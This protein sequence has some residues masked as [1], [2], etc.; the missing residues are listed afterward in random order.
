MKTKS[1]VSMTQKYIDNDNSNPQDV[2]VKE[3]VF[4][5]FGLVL[6]LIVVLVGVV[7]IGV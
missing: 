6:H 1:P 3:K 4:I 5:G 7:V 2:I